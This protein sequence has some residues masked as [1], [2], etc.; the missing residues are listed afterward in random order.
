[1]RRTADPPDGDSIAA[2]RLLLNRNEPAKAAVE[3]IRR[4]MA[5]VTTMQGS[6]RMA[7]QSSVMSQF[8]HK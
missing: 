8:Y 1:M 5:R 3:R 4:V 7:A 2:S 6:I